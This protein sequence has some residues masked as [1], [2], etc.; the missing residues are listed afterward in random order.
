LGVPARDLTADEY[1]AIPEDFRDE[2]QALYTP[3]DA[4]KES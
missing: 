1:A 3:V 4:G 2:A